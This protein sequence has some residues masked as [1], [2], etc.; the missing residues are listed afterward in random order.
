VKVINFIQDPNVIQ[1]TSYWSW[2]KFANLN[3]ERTQQHQRQY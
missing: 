3:V 1:G 2:G